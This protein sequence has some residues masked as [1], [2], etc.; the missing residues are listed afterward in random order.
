MTELLIDLPTGYYTDTEVTFDSLGNEVIHGQTPEFEINRT[1]YY[2]GKRANYGYCLGRRSL[3]WTDTSTLGDISNYLDTSQQANTV[4]VLGTTY[5]IRSTSAEDSSS[6]TGIRSMRINYLDGAGTRTITT[7]TLNGTTAVS[8]GNNISFVQYMESE[9]LGST[10]TAVGDITISTVT[11]TPT[12]AQTVEKIVAGDSR[13]MSGRVKVPTGFSL[14]L[15]G[16]RGS[17]IGAK[18]DLRIRGTV[19][20]DDRSLS[21]GFHFQQPMLLPDGTADTE[22][23]HYLKFPQ[24]SEVKVSAVSGGAPAGNRCDSSFHFLLIQN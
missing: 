8:L 17:A 19:F 9:T 11:G 10:L 16:W 12:S 7:V 15:L 23:F 21:Q 20:T 14:Y 3:G 2:R 24:G 6:G 22:D 4:V 13:S 5:Y 1:G 18:M